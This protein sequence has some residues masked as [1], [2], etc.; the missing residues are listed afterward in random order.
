ML[1]NFLGNI[2]L[3]ETQIIK[4]SYDFQAGSYVKNV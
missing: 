2:K 3:N 4:A 1:I